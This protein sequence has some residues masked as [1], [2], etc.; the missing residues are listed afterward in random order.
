MN[1]KIIHTAERCKPLEDVWSMGFVFLLH[2][3]SCVALFWLVS[4]PARDSDICRYGGLLGSGLC[5]T[6][7]VLLGSIFAVISGFMAFKVI[8]DL[9]LVLL[10]SPKYPFDPT[11]RVLLLMNRMRL[12]KVLH[13]EVLE[14]I[15]TVMDDNCQAQRTFAL[16]VKGMHKFNFYNHD[17]EPVSAD[18]IFRG[19]AL[20]EFSR[21]KNSAELDCARVMVSSRYHG[22]LYYGQLEL[23]A[24][25]CELRALPTARI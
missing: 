17:N 15:L 16:K 24:E 23:E 18:C 21:V 3:A 20:L 4:E 5:T 12:E 11:L 8:I 2:S 19:G 6:S 10:K 25:S 1:P 22:A 7:G 14:V 9:F 13:G